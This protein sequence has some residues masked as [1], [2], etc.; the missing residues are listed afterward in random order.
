VF[1]P[2]LRPAGKVEH[3]GIFRCDHDRK[4]RGDLGKFRDCQ[5]E[6]GARIMTVET[7]GGAELDRLNA[8]L[9]WWGVPSANDTEYIDGQVKRLHVFAANLQ[10]AC[11][12]EY[13][14][15]VQGTFTANQRLVLS[16][17]ALLR[18]RQPQEVIAVEMGIWATILE[19]VMRQ[20]QA[21][22][23]LTRKV[24]GCCAALAAMEARNEAS[25]RPQSTERTHRSPAGNGAH[26]SSQA[27]TSVSS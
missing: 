7:N 13:F 6:Q 9:A 27:I 10:K 17:E 20:A 5:L 24:Q 1:R 14:R 26:A 22:T 4:R 16:L 21:W 25:Q 15:Q 23:E 3:F 12:D 11:G 8:L 2:G 19:G 18:C